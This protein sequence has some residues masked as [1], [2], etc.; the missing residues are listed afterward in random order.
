[1]TELPDYIKQRTNKLLR[2]FGKG[3]HKPGSGSAAAFNGLLSCQLL[4]TVIKLST[5]GGRIDTYKESQEPLKEIRGFIEDI[6]YPKLIQLF[7]SDAEEFDKVIKLRDERDVL[8]KSKSKTDS[9]FQALSELE[10]RLINSLKVATRIPIEI[11]NICSELAKYSLR[12]YDLGWKAV[13]GDTGVS[14]NSALSAIAGC[15]QIISLNLLSIPGN[16]PE[17]HKLVEDFRRIFEQYHQLEATAKSKLNQLYTELDINYSFQKFLNKNQLKSDEYKSLKE[18][19]IESLA[20]SILN[21]L[22]KNRNGLWKKDIP[23]N[24]IKIINTKKVLKSL[25]FS[26]YSE[27]S[28]G[29]DLRNGSAEIGGIINKELKIVL[30]SEHR[31][32]AVQN[33]TLAHELGHALL[34]TDMV[35]HRDIPLHGDKIRSTKEPKERQADLFAVYFLMPKNQVIK[36]FEELFG[37]SQI[38]KKQLIPYDQDNRNFNKDLKY[39]SLI[40]ASLTSFKDMSSR[41]TMAK[42]FNVSKEAMAYRLIKLKLIID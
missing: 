34:H 38:R 3:G 8:I 18:E 10:N 14:I 26:H 29:V 4:L 1:M 23:N 31:G 36:V 7:Q 11:A 15:N 32:K 40:L 27:H 2:S 12:V 33:F 20:Y 16:D 39:Y 17:A 35:L 42:V 28:L 25:G 19:D 6:I 22:W 41:E 30:T 5:K 13:R 24:E 9:T 37:A 21:Q